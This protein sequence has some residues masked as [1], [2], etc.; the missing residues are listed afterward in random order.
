MNSLRSSRRGSCEVPG[1][2][3]LVRSTWNFI[4]GASLWF[5]PG[6][7]YRRFAVRT[8]GLSV[9]QAAVRWHLA[10]LA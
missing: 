10:H 5:A 6:E 1:C 9:G 3:I 4:L 8:L 7:E 2:V